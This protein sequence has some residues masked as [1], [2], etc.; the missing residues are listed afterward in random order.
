[1][2]GKLLYTGAT[3]RHCHAF[4]IKRQKLFLQQAKAVI[5]KRKLDEAK[6]TEDIM[7]INQIDPF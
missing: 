4:M 6:I 1:M 7:T 3:I 2:V 5:K